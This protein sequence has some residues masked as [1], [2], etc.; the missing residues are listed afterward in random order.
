MPDDTREPQHETPP[1]RQKG[2][3]VLPA[4]K[5]PTPKPDTVRRK[6]HVVLTAEQQ[7]AN[8][9]RKPGTVRQKGRPVLPTPHTG[10]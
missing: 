4:G 1:K 8:A 10:G 5:R 7:A 3:A 6:G 2:H 9:Q